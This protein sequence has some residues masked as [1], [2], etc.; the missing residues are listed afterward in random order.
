VNTKIRLFITENGIS[1][2]IN[3]MEEE[4]KLGLTDRDMKDIGKMTK[5]I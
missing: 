4:S 2:Q 3:V 1:P 5:P